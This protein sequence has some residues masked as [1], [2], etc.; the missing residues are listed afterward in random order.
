MAVNSQSEY[1]GRIADPDQPE[2]VLFGWL[3]A[4]TCQVSLPDG[5]QVLHKSA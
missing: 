1:P 5:R 4:L 3:V 2:L